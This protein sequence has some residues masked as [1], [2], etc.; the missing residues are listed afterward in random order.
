MVN[1]LSAPRKGV[2]PMKIQIL[3]TM[4]VALFLLCGCSSFTFKEY[5][6]TETIQGAGGTAR[7][8]D[9][10]DFWEKG[11]P[12][13]KYKVLGVISQSRRRRVP[14]GRLS[15]ILSDP[16]DSDD[17]D[18]AIAKAARKHGGDAVIFVSKNREQSDAG[19]FGD[20]KHR[21][22]MLVVVKYVE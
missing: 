15:R 18:S 5:Q 21:R 2:N 19:Q 22:P 11:E 12:D 17:R 1:Q 3:S 9:G 16:G 14:L 8:V 10:I 13:R 6:M 4:L 7:D 20:G